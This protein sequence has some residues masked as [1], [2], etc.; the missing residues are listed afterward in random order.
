MYAQLIEGQILQK[1]RSIQLLLGQR[2]I[3]VQKH[4]VLCLSNKTQINKMVTRRRGLG[5]STAVKTPLEAPTSHVGAPA[6][7]PSFYTCHL[8]SS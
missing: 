5:I 7:S 8:T 6:C 1:R 2:N 4:Y 3:H